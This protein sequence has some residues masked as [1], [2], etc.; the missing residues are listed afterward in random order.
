M[1]TF[2]QNDILK[3]RLSE[4]QQSVLSVMGI[5]QWHVRSVEIHDDGQADNDVSVN[6]SDDLTQQQDRQQKTTNSINA[7][8]D[9]LSPGTQS[10]ASQS[11]SKVTTS[12]EATT[13]TK[14]SSP[15]NKPIQ[16]LPPGVHLL[17]DVRDQERG[18]VDDVIASVKE[19]ARD[20]IRWRV[21]E[22]IQLEGGELL[23]PPVSAVMTNPKLKRQLWRLLCSHV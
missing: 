14:P 10:E 21:G 4:Y 3:N 23:T 20:A 9:A 7:L 8:R 16:E 6:N 2:D 5:S 22:S 1:N 11:Q 13:P 17:F 15:S 12:N 18:F 19:E